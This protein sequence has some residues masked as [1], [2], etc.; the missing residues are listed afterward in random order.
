LTRTLLAK[1][2]LCPICGLVRLRRDNQTGVCGYCQARG[3]LPRLEVPDL[4][5]DGPLLELPSSSPGAR[6]V[7]PRQVKQQVEQA[8]ELPGMRVALLRARL[9]RPRTRG[10][11]TE[12][13][14]P[15]PFVACRHHLA[16][17]VT[18]AGGIQ[19]NAPGGE[20]EGMAET[21]ALDVA[22]RGGQ[23]L[24][25]V[26]E[27]LGVVRERVRQIEIEALARLR[28]LLEEKGTTRE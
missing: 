23:T 20:L 12:G 14:R 19:V 5:A 13:L 2:A 10:H 8:R 1:A 22:D 25:Q 18:S 6:V 16:L 15:C 9:A 7:R 4:E 26:S 11:C 27:V 3:E 28:K 24:E 17:D 21:C